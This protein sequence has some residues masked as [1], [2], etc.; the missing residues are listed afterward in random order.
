MLRP[1]KRLRAKRTSIADVLDH[2]SARVSGVVSADS[3]LRAPYTGRKCVYFRLELRQ[4]QLDRVIDFKVDQ[5]CNFWIQDESGSAEVLVEAA[6]FEV[7]AD[8]VEVE[9]ASRLSE[10]GQEVV[11]TYGW[12][13]EDIAQVTI[14]EAIVPLAEPIDI[15]GRSVREPTKQATSE[16]RGFRDAPSTVPVFSSPLVLGPDREAVWVDTN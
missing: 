2:K 15:V 9:R 16:E 4:T 14:H 6:T 13:L 11:R 5:R 3:A 8:F 10:R 7:V 12:K 1:D